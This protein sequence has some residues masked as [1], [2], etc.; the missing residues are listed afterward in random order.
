MIRICII[1][2]AYL[3]L[4]LFNS[5]ENNPEYKD[6]IRFSFEDFPEPVFLHGEEVLFDEPLML[7]NRIYIIDSLLFVKNR[8][9]E[10][11]LHKYN[12]NT[13]SKTGECISFGSG[14]EEFIWLHKVIKGDS[15]T[16]LFD[17]Q[18]SIL[19]KYNRSDL[20]L[21]DSVS[22]FL[23]IYFEDHLDDILILQNGETVGTALNPTR[24]K[25][26]F[27]NEKGDFIQTKGEYPDFGKSLTPLEQLEGFVGEMVISPDSKHIFFFHK[28]TDLIEIYDLDGNVV[29][30]MH[31]PEHFFP[32]VVERN[33][34]GM[35]KVGSVP[36]H[37]RDG[38]FCPQLGINEIFV[39]Y[40]GAYYTPEQPNYLMHQLFVFDNDGNPIKRYLLD[41]SIFNFAV[42]TKSRKIYGIT[43]TPDFQIFQYSY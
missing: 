3:F 38:Y 37:S 29:K 15:V 39:L 7:P 32:Q 8:N 34:D 10:F 18:K 25:I 11:F 26:S 23:K 42:D 21:S 12:L 36:N 19:H 5:C 4:L 20:L 14:P 40:S 27:Y 2:F 22:S 33:F 6:C 35:K 16:W 30:R 41:K 1:I 9:T 24:K 13:L 28:Q 31:G 43:D 17:N